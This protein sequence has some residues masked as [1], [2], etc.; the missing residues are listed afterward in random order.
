MLIYNHWFHGVF[1]LLDDCSV[2]KALNHWLQISI[3]EIKY[4]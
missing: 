1:Y 3:H 2:K 4:I